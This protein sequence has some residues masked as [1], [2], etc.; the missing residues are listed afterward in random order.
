VE[1]LE[2]IPP[3][4]LFYWCLDLQTSAIAATAENGAAPSAL[5]ARQLRQIE[6]IVKTGTTEETPL[7]AGAQPI[8][9][10]EGYSLERRT[11]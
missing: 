8:A 5:G 11:K 2:S 6:I 10:C 4:R 9:L 1:Y 3:R 7:R